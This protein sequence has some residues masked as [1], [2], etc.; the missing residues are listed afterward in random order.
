MGLTC[1]TALVF[2]FARQSTIVAFIVVGLGVSAAGYNTADPEVLGHFSEVGILVLLFM[3]GLEVEIH[4]FI[5]Q[6]RTVTIVGVGQ[7]VFSTALNAV[8]ATVVLPAVGQ[9]ANTT[10]SIY[11]GLAMTFSSTILVLGFLK[12][13]KSMN[14]VY[15]QLC[16]GT[17]ILQDVASVLG[18]AILSGLSENQG[19]CVCEKGN[20][21]LFATGRMLAK[22][23]D[24]AISATD[25][26]AL[27]GCEFVQS[28]GNTVLESIF[29]LFGKLAVACVIFAFLAK[30]VLPR[31]FEMFARNFE[32]LFLGSMGY[33]T[34]MAA[35]AIAAG[36]SGEITAFLAGVSVSDLEYKL[37]MESKLEPIKSIGVAIFFLS[38]GLQIPLD[39][40]LVEAL[41]VGLGLALLTIVATLPLFL[42]L[43]CLAKLKALNCFMIGLLMNQI[44]EFSLIL[45]TLCVRAGVLDKAVLT[46]MTVAAVFSIVISSIGHIFIERMYASVQRS[47]CLKCIDYHH[48]GEL[49]AQIMAKDEEE[50]EEAAS[51]GVIGLTV[52]AGPEDGGGDSGIPGDRHVASW[53]DVTELKDCDV[54]QLVDL[55]HEAESD[56]AAARQSMSETV[57][58]K[59][60][61]HSSSLY[62]NDTLQNHKLAT[63]H[64][65]DIVHGLIEGYVIV[66]GHLTFCTLREGRMLFWANQHDVGHVPPTEVWDVSGMTMLAYEKEEEVLKKAK[67]FKNR[68]GSRSMKKLFLADAEKKTDKNVEEY[69]ASSDE[70][71]HPWEWTITLAHLHRSHN[72]LSTRE[73]PMKLCIHGL[74]DHSDHEFEDW[75]DALSVVLATLNPIALRRAQVKEEING[76]DAVRGRSGSVHLR[77][78]A[79]DHRNEIICLGYNEMFPAVLAL[80]DAVKKKLVVVEYDPVKIKFIK[81]SYNEAQRNSDQETKK[82]GGK[83]AIE[84]KGVT[85]SHVAEAEEQGGASGNRLNGVTCE[86]ADI[87]DPE[88]WEELG[89]DQAFM[90]VCTMP[91]AHHAEKAIIKWLQKHKSGSIFITF[92]DSSEETLHLYEAGAHFVMQTH[93]LAQRATK[94]IFME[95]V[96]N[97]GNCSQL[98]LAGKAHGNRLK[99]LQQEDA[100]RFMYETG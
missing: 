78:A 62:G 35:L 22:G 20:R 37:H 97:H 76:R 73:D 1:L 86:Y 32:L 3:A 66:D 36:F 15:G 54:A 74:Q 45:C 26:A 80:A 6:W 77:R 46:V 11:F 31:L 13:S 99:K 91:S 85:E 38:L 67:S 95:M 75:R 24:S 25:C 21:S 83:V 23:G 50:L 42:L 56:L 16:L 47:W 59:R 34:G 94:E 4:A 27:T 88:S 65:V 100:T 68:R 53:S 69:G 96:A 10:A 93:A 28:S 52:R 57:E 30:F 5:V 60:T 98:V 49:L 33:C 92:A 90:L 7:I 41:P 29:I 61:H 48:R 58:Q 19:S 44:S 87:H 8:L 43:G 84:P 9:T 64:A 71:F 18:L 70:E 40:T 82:K 72:A 14:T 2:S 79:H 89:M 63:S 39:H 81:E 17:L 51:V 55:L 12:K